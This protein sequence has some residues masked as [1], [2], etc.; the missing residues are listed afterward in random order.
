MN[1]FRTNYNTTIALKQ[2]LSDCPIRPVSFN[3]RRR[4]A[5]NTYMPVKRTYSMRFCTSY[6][7]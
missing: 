5:R 1:T 3:I 6:S 2:F 7:Y 4:P